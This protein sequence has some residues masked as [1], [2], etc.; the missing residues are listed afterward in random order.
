LQFGMCGSTGKYNP[1]KAV[2]SI[3]R[4][5]IL[6]LINSTPLEVKRIAEKLD[7]SREVKESLTMLKKCGLVKEI[8]GRYSPSFAIFTLQDQRIL[9]SLLKELTFGVK[10]ILEKR[11]S[12][13][14]RL[15]NDLECTRRGLNFPDLQYIIVGAITLDYRA[16]EVLKDEEL[17][18]PWKEMPGNGNYIFSGLELGLID[19]KE[20]W[21]W[22]NNSIYGKYWFST[23]GKMPSKGRMAFPDL[24]WQWSEHIERNK[25]KR[26]MEKIGEILEALLRG[27]L[28]VKDLNVM[29]R[30]GEEELLTELT[31]LWALEYV[32]PAEK[33]WKIN[34]PFFA[35][36][37]LEKIRTLSESI[38]REVSEFFEG[39]QPRI[40]ELY[41]QTSPS[42]NGIPFEEAFNLLYHLIFEET[43]NVLIENEIINGPPL[44]KDGGRYSPF[45]GVGIENPLTLT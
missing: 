10:E 27:D 26:K 7:L 28:S 37:D 3:N 23:H 5:R 9:G 21:M 4:Q 45:I 25:I 13:V 24:T 36:N 34:R 44:R 8:N 35:S 17:L 31:L 40:L 22:G 32:I 43:L 11:L 20:S 30:K 16:L 14:I 2:E 12:E 18:L 29:V 41:G 6:L 1:Y 33:K 15:I 42:K 38:L 39:K 19:L